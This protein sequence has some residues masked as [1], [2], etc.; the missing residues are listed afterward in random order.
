MFK[1]KET[2]RRVNTSIEFGGCQVFVELVNLLVREGL[3][4]KF[5]KRWVRSGREVR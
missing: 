3:S 4:L 1:V 2:H 5:L